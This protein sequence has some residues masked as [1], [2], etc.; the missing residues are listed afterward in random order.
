MVESLVNDKDHMMTLT[1]SMPTSYISL[2]VALRG[3]LNKVGCNIQYTYSII[4]TKINLS[5]LDASKYKETTK[6]IIII[7]N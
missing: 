5:R 7:I 2:S 1:R 3:Q 4:N 6:L